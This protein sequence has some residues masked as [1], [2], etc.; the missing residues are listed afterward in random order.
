MEQNEI[1]N[2]INGLIKK[3]HIHKDFKEDLFQELYL[4]FLQL[5]KRY[6]P[7]AKVPFEAFII[8]FLTWRMW[9]I[10]LKETIKKPEDIYTIID[11]RDEESL[12]IIENDFSPYLAEGLKALESYE[13]ELIYLKYF[14]N[15]S[16]EDLAKKT[17]LSTEGVRKKL[18]KIQGK[19]K[20][21]GKIGRNG[22]SQKK[23][24]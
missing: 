4:Y 22:D 13:R 9:S 10:V 20:W 3:A 17:N 18:F 12:T 24:G 5:E 8:K 14:C 19:I 23:E 6:L 1:T 2:I 21:A 16:Y 7:E 15:A 11:L